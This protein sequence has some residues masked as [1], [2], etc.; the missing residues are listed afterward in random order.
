MTDLSYDQ[1]QFRSDQVAGQASAI[2]VHRLLR[3]VVLVGLAYYVGAR[4]GFD[5]TLKPSPV[6]TLWPPNSILLAAFLLTPV[7]M[8]WA[9]LGGAF[10]AHLAVQLQGGIP[11]PMVLGWFVSNAS[12]ALIGATIIRRNITGPLHFE[13]FRHVSIFVLAA[14]VG[15]GFSSFLDAGFVTL[16]GWGQAGYWDVWLTR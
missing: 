9:L 2:Q 6:S 11:V 5:L 12:E 13:S 1:H 10:V 7:S 16:V 3:A 8:W 4:I 15:T 14:F